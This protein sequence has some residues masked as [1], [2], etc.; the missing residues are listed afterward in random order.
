MPL[1]GLVCGKARGLPVEF[2]HLAVLLCGGVPLLGQPA[3]R[4][5]K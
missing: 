1:I 4:F 2:A 3:S 5:T